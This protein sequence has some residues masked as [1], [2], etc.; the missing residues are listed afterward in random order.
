MLSAIIVYGFFAVIINLLKFLHVD[1]AYK[2]LCSLIDMLKQSPFK[3][4]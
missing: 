2:L 4:S 1:V 3:F